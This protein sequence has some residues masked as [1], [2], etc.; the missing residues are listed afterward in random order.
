MI[1][2]VDTKEISTKKVSFEFKDVKKGIYWIRC[3]QDLNG[4]GKL[5]FG[6]FGPIEP[7]GYVSI[8]SPTF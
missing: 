6:L 2:N 7:W 5:D 3:F 1:I 4:N 8:M